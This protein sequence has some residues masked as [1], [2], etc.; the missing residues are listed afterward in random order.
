LH[1]RLRNGQVVPMSWHC[2]DASIN[3]TALPRVREEWHDIVRRLA[4][5]HP[6]FDDWG[7]FAYTNGAFKPWGDYLTEIDVGIWE[8][9]LDDERWSAWVEA[10]RDIAAV[11]LKYGGSISA[12]H[13]SCRAGEVDLVPQE[14]GGGFEVMKKV[15]HAL[16]P[17]N[18]MNPGKY[19]LDRAYEEGT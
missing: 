9:E 11:A 10:K 1:G 4:D 16:D 17:N 6:I 14:L 15:K 19:L 13:G 18:I 8:Q 2:E 3:W 12:C 5:R 7:M